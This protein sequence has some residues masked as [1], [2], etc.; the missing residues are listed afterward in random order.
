MSEKKITS[1]LR[2]DSKRTSFRPERI[3]SKFEGIC[4]V[5]FY[6]IIVENVQP[7]L[8]I[9]VLNALNYVLGEYHMGGAVLSVLIKRYQVIGH[10]FAPIRWQ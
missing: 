4:T 5:N 7:D 8:E 6:V 3:I 10:L 1:F 9:F 2:C